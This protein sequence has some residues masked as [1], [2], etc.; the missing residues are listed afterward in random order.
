MR[1]LLCL[2]GI[3]MRYSSCV[4]CY[5]VPLMT[6][7][8]TG[9]CVNIMLR[10]IVHAII[11]EE[12]TSYIQ[13]KH[14]RKTIYTRHQCFLKSYHPYRRLKKVFNRSQE[15]DSASIPLTSQQVLERVEDIN[16]ILGKTQK[17]E[18]KAKLPYG[19]RDRYCLI[20]HYWFDLDV[21][22]CIDVMHVKKKV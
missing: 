1:G 12:D 22:H 14:G 6:F 10:A 11:Y 19:R 13:L 7:Q 20:F 4:Q 8:H 2:M 3:K 18:K 9:I 16:T 5:F 15:H 21:R 17:K